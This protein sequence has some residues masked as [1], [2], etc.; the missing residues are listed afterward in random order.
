MFLRQNTQKKINELFENYYVKVGS[1]NKL[2]IPP[3]KQKLKIISIDIRILTKT[4]CHYHIIIERN[5]SYDRI[6]KTFEC[7]LDNLNSFQDLISFFYNAFNCTISYYVDKTFENTYEQIKN[8]NNHEFIGFVV[9]VFTQKN[10][11]KLV[12]SYLQTA[13]RDSNISINYNK[14]LRNE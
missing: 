4:L 6:I 3:G 14:H 1:K 10:N 11:K 8:Y 2:L 7:N 9:R 5:K 12:A 13:L